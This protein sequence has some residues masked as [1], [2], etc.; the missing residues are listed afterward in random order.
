M[1][2]LSPRLLR[3]S[4]LTELNLRKVKLALGIRH[5]LLASTLLERLSHLF[6]HIQQGRNDVRHLVVLSLITLVQRLILEPLLIAQ[7]KQNVI[8]AISVNRLVFLVFLRSTKLL[9]RLFTELLCDSVSAIVNLCGVPQLLVYTRECIPEWWKIF[10]D[11]SSQDLGALVEESELFEKSLPLFHETGVQ[12]E[13]DDED[14]QYLSS[15]GSI[16]F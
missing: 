12:N 8:V 6:V 11:V 2:S 15:I 4:I 5:G 9:Q 13:E 3:Q 1:S 10:V 7:I 16:K 14:E